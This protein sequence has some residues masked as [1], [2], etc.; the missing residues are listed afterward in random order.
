MSP[1]LACRW[2]DPGK[3]AA[4]AT[5]AGAA[6]S[7]C[8]PAAQ[9]AV[10]YFTGEIA[11]PQGKL[12]PLD[13]NLD[14]YFDINLKNYVFGGGN[15]QGAFLPYVGGSLVGFADNAGPNGTTLNYASA[16]GAGA[17]VDA[18]AVGPFV[19]SLAYGQKNPSAQ[20]RNVQGAYLGFRFPAG[21]LLHYAWVRVDVNNQAGTFFVRDWA[22][23][24]QP[25]VSILAGE[26]NLGGDLDGNGAVDGRDLL[27]WQRQAGGAWGADELAGWEAV[28]GGAGSTAAA[29]PV[30]EPGSLGLL[31]AGA[32]GL[33]LL[34]RRRTG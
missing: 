21:D 10:Q 24:D 2:H 5:A 20:F 11:I 14:E 8:S 7:A 27:A 26:G 30:P 12:Q 17:L 33:K 19:G 3:R 28:W 31:A 23:E 13:L 22:Y 25:G 4:Y 15:Y 1:A 34:R 9:A 16:L 18:T 29:A 32:A 6:L